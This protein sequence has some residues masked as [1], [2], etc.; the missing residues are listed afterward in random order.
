MSQ[1]LWWGGRA[2]KLRSLVVTQG[3]YAGH[4]I[5]AQLRDRWIP[6]EPEGPE[7][8]TS[9]EACAFVESDLAVEERRREKGRKMVLFA[10]RGGHPGFILCHQP[11]PSG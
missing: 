7:A 9:L 2:T 10:R 1:H 11:C 3:P 8:T 4:G 5:T 6:A